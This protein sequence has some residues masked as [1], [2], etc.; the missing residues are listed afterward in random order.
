MK[1]A[2][3]PGFAMARPGLRFCG[4][5]DREL[6]ALPPYVDRRPATIG[7]DPTATQICPNC[8]RSGAALA[9]FAEFC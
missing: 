6:A 5:A 3:C 4:C 8:A 2:D 9:P 7:I 1:L